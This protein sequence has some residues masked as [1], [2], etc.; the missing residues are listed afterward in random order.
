MR[1]GAIETN[2]HFAAV[3]DGVSL[4]FLGDSRLGEEGRLTDLGTAR[5]GA[6]RLANLAQDGKHMLLAGHGS[7]HR[8]FRQRRELLRGYIEA[9][10]ELVVFSNQAEDLALF[11]WHES[12]TILRI[13]FHRAQLWR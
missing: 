10:D 11:L 2:Q 8:A 4:L 1:G 12:L 3:W 5:R 7:E 13:G 9:I 6:A